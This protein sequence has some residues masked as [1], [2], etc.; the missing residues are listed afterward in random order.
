ML[1]EELEEEEERSAAALERRSGVRVISREEA[2][3]KI[4][5]KNPI[6]AARLRLAWDRDYE[7][8]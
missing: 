1:L 8:R 7:R 6:G 4:A 3:A 5:A 2:L